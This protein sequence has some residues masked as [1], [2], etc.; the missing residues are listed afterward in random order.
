MRAPALVRDLRRRLRTPVPWAIVGVFWAI[1]SAFSF[2]VYSK[3][4][5]SRATTSFHAVLMPGLVSF[6]Y[7]FL[8][9]LPWRFTSDDRL[10]AGM[11]RGVI[12]S[13]L[14]NTVFIALL[15][16]LSLAILQAGGVTIPDSGFS[17]G[18]PERFLNQMRSQLLFGLPM[19]T[20]VGGLISMGISTGD[21]KEQALEQLQEAQWVLLRGQLSP[22]VLFNALNGLAE[23]VHRDPRAAESALLNLSALYRALLDHGDKMRASLGDERR[24]VDRY[25]EVEQMRLGARLRVA[26]D[27]DAQLDPL[28]APPF[29]V[30]PLVEN[31]LKHGISPSPA[32]G[33]LRIRLKRELYGTTLRVSNTG[34]PA[35]LVLGQGIGI[36]NLEAR[37]R[38]AYKGKA[39]FRLFQDQEWTVAEITLP[40]GS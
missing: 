8:T 32:G 10:W 22:H 26:W 34:Q 11:V 25:L 40:E 21:E 14:A 17:G 33:E 2:I 12:Q 3:L 6:T 16:A 13:L 28:M 29:L 7:G 15:T 39:S 9:P 24:L 18:H 19:M 37:L 30:Q 35:P 27:W 4:P 5:G 38:L 23:L 20:V 36:A 1:F 31:A